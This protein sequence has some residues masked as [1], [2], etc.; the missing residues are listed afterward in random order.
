MPG[1]HFLTFRFDSQRGETNLL[2]SSSSFVL[3]LRSVFTRSSCHLF[4]RRP[5]LLSLLGGFSLF[6]LI[7]CSHILF[8]CA[9]YFSFLL[10]IHSLIFGMPHPSLSD[11]YFHF[12]PCRTVLNSKFFLESSFRLLPRFVLFSLLLK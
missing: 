1:L 4:L 11:T 7:S 3:D 2:I 5:L 9:Y 8:T 6:C 12:S 10:L